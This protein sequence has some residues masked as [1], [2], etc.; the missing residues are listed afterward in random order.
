MK[1]LGVDPGLRV[2]GYGLLE[3]VGREVRVLDAG[4]IR[5]DSDQELS[6]RLQSIYR[7]FTD[8]IAESTPAAVAVEDLYAHYKHPLTAVKMA[9]ARGAILLAAAQNGV[10]I[11]SYA[12]TRVKKSLTGNGRAGKQQMQQAITT[13]LHLPAVPEPPDV[14]DALALALCCLS[15]TAPI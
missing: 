9:H 5:A 4:L 15:E 14:A 11:R 10:E 12:A 8:L 2:S 6:T 1:I 3:Q 13:Q 7:D